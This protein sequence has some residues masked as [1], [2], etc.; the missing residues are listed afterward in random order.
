MS[1]TIG[2]MDGEPGLEIAVAQPGQVSHRSSDPSYV[3][4]YRLSPTGT[5]V[6]LIYTL[7]PSLQTEHLFGRTLSVADVT[8]DG[9][10]DLLTG[11]AVRD[12]GN[13]VDAGA[14]LVF[15][16]T[17]SATPYRFSPTPIVLSV[18]APKRD[19]RIGSGVFVGNANSDPTGQF[20]VVALSGTQALIS[21]SAPP[22]RG[23]VFR[24]PVSATTKES[25]SD[26]F[27]PPSVAMANGWGGVV[28]LVADLDQN[29]FSDLVVGAPG[30]DVTSACTMTGAVYVF[31]GQGGTQFAGWQRVQLLQP[32]GDPTAGDFGWAT[33]AAPLWHLLF[34]SDIQR[35]VGGV[36][37]AGQ[38]Y[39][40]RVF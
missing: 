40:Y 23:V 19:D 12:F 5:S 17:G 22:V 15:P 36:E 14:V 26:T 20:D 9:R 7:Q 4:V 21:G 13:A 28:P 35:T 39:V 16:G 10:P 33:A 38:I 37:F 3:Y 27:T 29:G 34:V 31:L 8:G 2:E 24:G 11:D 18:S 32:P 6:Q 1:L 30:A 25:A